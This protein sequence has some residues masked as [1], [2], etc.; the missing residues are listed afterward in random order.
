MQCL[1]KF[2][3]VECIIVVGS[4]IVVFKSLKVFANSFFSFLF[5]GYYVFW[6]DLWEKHFS[7]S[8]KFIL[9]ILLAGIATVINFLIFDHF[10][11]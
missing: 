3:I 1:S 9:F 4:A 7:R 2:I 11:F 5:S 6:N 8:M 10:I